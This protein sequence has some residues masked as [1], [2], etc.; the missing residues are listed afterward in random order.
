LIREQ[1]GSER[2]LPRGRGW[3]GDEKCD[4]ETMKKIIKQELIEPNEK[5]YEDV[6]V[7]TNKIHTNTLKGGRTDA[8]L[9]YFDMSDYF[10]TEAITQVYCLDKNIIQS[11]LK[12]DLLREMYK[13]NI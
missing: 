3:I 11:I 12:K 7:H 8:S 2:G 6:L 10:K 5:S 9:E 13:I 4:A 1:T